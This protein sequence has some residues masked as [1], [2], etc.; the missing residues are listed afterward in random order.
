MKILFVS[1]DLRTIG[2]I[3]GH[4]RMLMD[5][6]RDE[7]VRVRVVER[8]EGDILAKIFFT[9]RFFFTVLL[10]RPNFMYCPNVN[11]SLLCFIAKRLFGIRY[12]IT[13]HGIEAVSLSSAFVR[14]VT[15]ADL[16]L[17]PFQFTMD[18][19]IRQ[20]PNA[21][22]HCLIFP[23][24]FEAD[25]F[26]IREKSRAMLDRL[27]LSDSKIIVTI[28]RVTKFDGDGKGYRRVIAALPEIVM[29]VPNVKYL[30]VGGGDD[31]EDTKIFTK[32]LGVADRVVMPGI[33]TNEEIVDYYN[34]GD[35][36]VL[37]SKREGFPAIVLFEALA[38]GVPVVGGDQPGSDLAPWNGEVALI[39]AADDIHSIAEKI[40]TILTHRAPARFYDRSFLRERMLRDY[41]PD[42]YRARVR[43]LLSLVDKMGDESLR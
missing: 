9:L 17:S 4:V 21:K 19:V 22:E 5:A 32:Q 16:V 27:H 14:S 15:S 29:A 35:V 6:F 36:F 7:G 10:W 41:G 24:S 39:A 12:S 40:I 20:V 28:C 26:M 42:A 11:F 23:N 33:A 37:P 8:R 1:P 13:F 43:Q 3:Q 18:N 38:C 30:L 31:L 34:L 25:R 2:G